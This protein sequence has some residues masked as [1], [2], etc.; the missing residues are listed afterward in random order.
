M[1]KHMH[2]VTQWQVDS[3]WPGYTIFAPIMN[4][5]K[6]MEGRD[7]SYV[8]L[9]DMKGDI[10]HYW[11]IPGVIKHHGELLPNGHLLCSVNLK[12][13]KNPLGLTFATSAIIEL[14][15]DSNV[16]WRYDDVYHDGH[17]RSRL[18]N[19]N[20]L[21][22]RYKLLPEEKQRLVKGGE[23]GTEHNGQMFTLVLVEIT[24]DG[25][26]VD[27]MDLSEALDPEV[28]VIL[29]YSNRELWP[30]LNSIEEMPDGKI[31]STSYN[32]SACYIWDRQNK[33]VAWRYGKGEQKISFPH[34]PHPLANGNILLFDNGRDYA[35]DP[36]G[37]TNYFPPDFSRV[38]EINPL[39]NETV[40]EY[41]A[42][43][44]VDF[45]STYISSCQ[46]LPNDN[47]LICEGAIGR[48]FE[49]NRKGEIVWEYVS[50]FYTESGKRFGKTSAV[51]RAIRY[52]FDYSGLQPEA[53][54]TDKCDKINR[55]YGSEAM[56]F[57]NALRR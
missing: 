22:M 48:I 3:A 29:P 11:Q 44:P 37:R 33:T 10:V 13:V 45:Y 5:M 32:L 50:P 18:S 34:D 28:D 9:L 2:G 39:T 43:N 30:G 8:Y 47:T 36:D 24:P 27:E 17:D 54:R 53:F 7:H 49:V 12:D 21:Y 26:I 52:S 56:R 15:W 19:G 38:V 51:F 1:R 35:P 55:L 46:R 14:D 42:E 57:A 16:V 20:T 31:I 6:Q 40:W 25:Q 4:T 23:P 41:R